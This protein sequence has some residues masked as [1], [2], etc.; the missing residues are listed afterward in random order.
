MAFMAERSGEINKEELGRW[1]RK[2][3]LVGGEPDWLG[4]VAGNPGR[5]MW[6]LSDI[7]P[8]VLGFSEPLPTIPS[9]S[10]K[11]VHVTQKVLDTLET[12]WDPH[13]LE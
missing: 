7:G 3:A 1:Q 5:P 9:D 4:A 10:S 2:S 12:T 13:D 8:V 6:N 11:D